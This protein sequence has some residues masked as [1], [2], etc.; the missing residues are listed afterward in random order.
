MLETDDTHWIFQQIQALIES[1]Q[2]KHISPESVMETNMTV[3][4]K[5]DNQLK[6]FTLHSTSGVS[7]WIRYEGKFTEFRCESVLQSIQLKV[8]R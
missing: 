2:L 1:E 7:A 4:F 5:K 6:S 8:D 3:L